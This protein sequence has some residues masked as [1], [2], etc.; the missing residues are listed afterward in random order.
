MWEKCTMVSGQKAESIASNSDFDLKTYKTFASSLMISL[1]H[2]IIHFSVR[3]EMQ[4]GTVQCH[5]N[6]VNFLQNPHNG[7]LIACLW[8]WDMGCL[9]WFKSPICVLPSVQCCLEYHFELNCV[10][11]AVCSTHPQTSNISHT[12]VGNKL[13]DPSDVVGASPVGA[14]P[15]TSSLST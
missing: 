14:A 3:K 12:L 10:T 8:G 7:H 2:V 5:Y 1:L 13:V 11:A 6:K 4:G 9:L 15:N